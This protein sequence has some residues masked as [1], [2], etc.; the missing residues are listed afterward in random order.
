MIAGRFIEK[1]IYIFTGLAGIHAVHTTSVCF[2]VRSDKHSDRD[3]QG[4]SRF[5]R[6]ASL[7]SCSSPS[8]SHPL[9]TYIAPLFK[10]LGSLQTPQPARQATR[11]RWYRPQNETLK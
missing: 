7:K 11:S 10:A 4:R 6:I 5:S 9:T 2:I 8:R 1:P 3:S